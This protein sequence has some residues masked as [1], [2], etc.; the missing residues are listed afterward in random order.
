LCYG[1]RR[2][3]MQENAQTLALSSWHPAC[4]PT[5]QNGDSVLSHS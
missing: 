3:V 5:V 1:E 4:M 2:K